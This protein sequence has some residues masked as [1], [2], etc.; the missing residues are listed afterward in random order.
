MHRLTRTGTCLNLKTKLLKNI[1]EL[2]FGDD[3]K[4]NH[5]FLNLTLQKLI[6]VLCIS[7]Q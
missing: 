2:K 1:M 3:S 7:N 4:Q 5:N 6:L